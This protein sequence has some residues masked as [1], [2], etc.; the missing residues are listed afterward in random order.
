M[1]A[2]ISDRARALFVVLLA[3]AALVSVL[4]AIALLSPQRAAATEGWNPPPAEQMPALPDQGVQSLV[5]DGASWV[6]TVDAGAS[7]IKI[8]EPMNEVLCGTNYGKPCSTVYSLPSTATCVMV[9]VDWMNGPHNSTDPWRCKPEPSPEP[10]PSTPPT[11]E[12]SPEPTSTPEPTEEPSP[13]PSTSP[14]PP[15][16]P[17]PEPEPSPPSSPE[18]SPSTPSTSPSPTSPEP[19]VNPG[20]GSSS[21]EAPLTPQGRSA[22][23]SLTEL[24]ATGSSDAVGERVMYLLIF[25][26]VIVG[27]GVLVFSMMRGPRD[28]R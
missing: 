10:Q 4:C 17:T 14:Q 11:E 25:G 28:P 1:R 5:W 26:I 20:R 21:P 16:T 23:S 19:S 8:I 6:L 12:P 18:P 22:D 24:P 27:I 7:E 15:S 13:E 9:Q 3:L 2:I